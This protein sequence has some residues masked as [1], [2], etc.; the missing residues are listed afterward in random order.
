MCNQSSDTTS[1]R[2]PKSWHLIDS[3]S[4]PLHLSPLLT[5]GHELI[6]SSDPPNVCCD[7]TRILRAHHP[8]RSQKPNYSSIDKS[9]PISIVFQ[10]QHSSGESHTSHPPPSVPLQV[11][12]ASSRF[13]PGQLSWP[14]LLLPPPL[15]GMHG[16]PTW[17]GGRRCRSPTQT[18]RRPSGKP[19][20]RVEMGQVGGGAHTC[21]YR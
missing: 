10:H 2:N 5:V 21:E 18:R 13:H 11:A 15:H 4:D 6:T 14:L 16:T 7:R 1:N 19:P 9:D 3:S 8:L 17:T 20:C 12:R